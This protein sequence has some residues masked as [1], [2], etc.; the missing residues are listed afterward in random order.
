MNFEPYF[1]VAYAALLGIFFF[2]GLLR[3]C[4]LWKPLGMDADTLYPARRIVACVYFS[5][6]LL[7]PCALHPLSPDARLLARCFWVLFVP[8]ATSLGY[9]RFFYGDSRHSLL[10]VVLIGVVPLVFTLALSGIALAG[11]DV[12][13]PHRKAV[14]HAAGVLGALLTAYQLHVMLWLWHI[15]SGADAV[16]RSAD[17]LF[18][19]N[20]ASK[21]LLVSLAVLI[22]TW[23]DFLS[24]DMSSNTLL[25]GVVAFAGAAILFTILHPQ[26]VDKVSVE[27]MR[28]IMVA[29]KNGYTVQVAMPGEGHPTGDAVA[30]MN[31][32]FTAPAPCGTVAEAEGD[33]LETEGDVCEVKLSE[34]AGT[35]GNTPVDD[36]LTDNEAF[37]ME[38]IDVD[39]EEDGDES[40]QESDQPK[41]K[42]YMLSDAQLDNMERQI[43]KFVEGRKQYLDPTLTRKTLE[44]KL[45]VN[46]LYLSEVCARRFG[47]LT[48]YLNTL[49]MEH[50]IRY[51][52]EHPDAKQAEVVH[53]SGFGSDTSYYRAKSTYEAGKLSPESQ[54]SDNK[55]DNSDLRE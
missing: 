45:G 14:I 41:E 38:D 2:C 5:V 47:S 33:N 13:V 50:A 12:L 36:G 16:A 49:R 11:G 27:K 32:A 51:A 55:I 1:G 22:F 39:A 43:R 42:K 26:R 31:V 23:M 20:F 21:M 19:Y 54:K 8:A 40:P 29:I 35:D 37:V 34:D 18:P 24:D 10:R 4:D 28:K 46:R 25:A 53:H 6:M 9:K 52:A 3:C 15:R 44:K 48:L 17:K 30:H 7:L